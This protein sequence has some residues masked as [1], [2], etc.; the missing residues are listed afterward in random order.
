MVTHIKSIGFNAKKELRD[1]INVKTTKLQR[2]CIDLVKIEVTLKLV[3]TFSKEAK[4][5]EIRLV[6]PGNDLIGS[7]AA[8]SFEEAVLMTIEI[9]ERRLETRKNK[10]IDYSLI[11]L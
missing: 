5:C 1:F 3:G 11:I 8:Q 9:L 2:R 4:R 6:I 7:C 10:R